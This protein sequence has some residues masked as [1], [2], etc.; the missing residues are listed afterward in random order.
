MKKILSFILV[1]IMVVTLVPVSIFA[2]SGSGYGWQWDDAVSYGHTTSLPSFN[3]GDVKFEFDASL[4]R[5]AEG[6]KF[7]MWTGGEEIIY[8]AV[9]GTA[10]FGTSAVGT[11]NWGE[12]SGTAW[13]HIEYVFANGSATMFIDGTSVV[14]RTG[15]TA[16]AGDMVFFSYHGI[17]TMDNF[18]ISTVSTGATI[19]DCDFED[20]AEANSLFAGSDG[21]GARVELVGAPDPIDPPAAEDIGYV[22]RIDDYAALAKDLKKVEYTNA[23]CGSVEFDMAFLPGSSGTAKLEIF[24]GYEGRTRINILSN[25]VGYFYAMTEEERLTGYDWGALNLSN[26]KHVK[27]VHSNTNILLYIDGVQVY[28][29]PYGTTPAMSGCV[30]YVSEGSALIDNLVFTDDT[31]AVQRSYDFETNA[32]DNESDVTDAERVYIGDC[33]THGHVPGNFTVRILDPTCTE[34][35]YDVSYCVVCAQIAEQIPVAKLGHNFGEYTEGKVTTAA[36]ATTDGKLTWTCKRCSAATATGTQVA[37]GDYTGKIIAFDDMT[38]THVTTGMFKGFTVPEF[39]DQNDGITYPADTI[40]TEDG[41]SYVHVFNSQTYRQFPNVDTSGYTVSFD[42]RHQGTHDT[43]D[44]PNYGHNIHFWFGGTD[45]IHNMAGYDFDTGAFYFKPSNGSSY[46]AL[47]A[48]YTLEEDTWYNITFRYYSDD[49]G[50][51]WAALE[52]NGEEILRFDDDNSMFEL[53]YVVDSF[54]V[55]MRTFGVEYDVTNFVIGDADFAWTNFRTPV[56]E[57]PVT[58]GDVD[59]NGKINTR[60][61]LL[62][63]RYIADEESVT[64]TFNV[65]N[66]DYTQDGRI[67]TRDLASLKKYLATEA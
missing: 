28:N 57:D 63:K 56:T 5:G 11:Y 34:D 64:G 37:T 49:Y 41:V 18:K 61:L 23:N 2:A 55:L 62:L 50:W 46:D 67:N 13:H 53:P 54:P 47:T 51:S 9:N 38:D 59:E 44:T 17:F 26:W 52:V 30:F 39:A 7:G 14:S 65:A 58:P 32:I 1:A 15:V 43:N 48:A 45:G 19:V 4:V 35:G 16:R 21:L 6:A 3:T 12:L 66:A 33:D 25:S 31:G 42:F 36:T 24:E 40:V 22:Y 20:A 10:T 60:D 8:D 29:I 27:Y